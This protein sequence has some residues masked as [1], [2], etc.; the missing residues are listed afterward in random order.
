MS[1]CRGRRSATRSSTSLPRNES[2]C[3]RDL[4]GSTLDGREDFQHVGG[5]RPDTEVGVGLAEGDCAVLQDDE[6]RRQWEAPAGFGRGLV[7]SPGVYKRDV[8]QYPLVVAA[9]FFW[10]AVGDA[11]LL[12]D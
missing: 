12:G 5:L 11:E 4:R 8:D 3:W 10:N 1:A 6:E 7:G 9:V 2:E